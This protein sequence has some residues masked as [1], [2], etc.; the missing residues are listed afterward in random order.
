MFRFVSASVITVFWVVIFQAFGWVVFSG[1]FFD[2]L[3]ISLLTVMAVSVVTL[4]GGAICIILSH[5]TLIGRAV[6]IILFATII[7]VISGKTVD[8][9]GQLTNWFVVSSGTF[10]LFAWILVIPTAAIASVFKI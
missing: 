10:Y 3:L 9:I 6:A 8:T 5:I 2:A 4:V 7:L 1:S